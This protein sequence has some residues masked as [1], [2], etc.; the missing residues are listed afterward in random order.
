MANFIDVIHLQ[1][2]PPSRPTPHTPRYTG[3]TVADDI[4]LTEALKEAEA[5]LEKADEKVASVER[6]LDRFIADRQRL[7]T[8]VVVLR[9]A[10]ERYGSD[11]DRTALP[12][13]PTPLRDEPPWNLLSRA[14]AVLRVLRE[15]G[16]PMAPVEI[17][18]VLEAVGRPNDKAHY[19]S[20]V[21]NYLRSKGRVR[22]EGRGQWVIVPQA[23]END[24]GGEQLALAGGP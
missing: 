11:N 19:V 1:I 20:A 23:D 7:R 5:D 12:V 21:L 17:V 14:A 8:M 15:N 24:E 16:Q 3:F 2:E 13:S 18:K 4:A 9:D 10:I 22:N 6:V